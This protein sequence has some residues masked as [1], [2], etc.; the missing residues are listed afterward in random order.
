MDYLIGIDGG[1]TKTKCIITNPGGEVLYECTGGPSN[2]LAL[3]IEKVCE[4]LFALIKKCR[5]HLNINFSDI[6][7]ICLGTGGGGRKSD[8]IR[9]EKAFTEYSLNQGVTVNSFHVESDARRALE[10]AFSGK[11]GCILISGTGSIM[12]GKDNDGNIYRVGGFGRLIG[13]EGSGYSIGRKGLTAVSKELDGRGGHTLISDLI[14]KELKINTPEQ[15]I[16]AAYNNLDISSIAFFVLESAEQ[17]DNEAI[18]ILNQESD[19]LIAHI[20]SMKKKFKGANLNIA[21]VGSLIDNTNIFLK[22]L[23]AKMEIKLPEIVIRKPEQP[24]AMG[25]II[26]AK[27]ILKAHKG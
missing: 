7:I 4:N 24:P 12:T 6:K 10:G 20:I 21:L 26:M 23:L 18:K 1:G 2:F 3:D 11:P 27:E 15:L 16:S 9:L 17:G 25:A 5:D 14:A 13:D 22:L 19:E 8:A